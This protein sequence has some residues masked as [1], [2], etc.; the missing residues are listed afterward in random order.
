MPNDIASFSTAPEP[1]AQNEPTSMTIIADHHPSNAPEST[2]TFSTARG[3]AEQNDTP[4]DI[5][6]FSTAPE[7]AAQNEPTSMT[8]TADHHTNPSYSAGTFSS[9]RGPVGQNDTPN[10]IASFSTAPEPAEQNEPAS[11]TFTAHHNPANVPDFS[12]TFSTAP[13]PAA[14]SEPAS[15]TLASAATRTFDAARE[16]GGKNESPNA[17]GSFSTSPEP[18]RQNE[19]TN[20]TYPK[21]DHTTYTLYT[22]EALDTAPKPAAQEEPT[23][24][25][26]A[27][28]D[29][30]PLSQTICAA[31]VKRSH[32]QILFR[33]ALIFDHDPRSSVQPERALSTSASQPDFTSN[34]V[35]QKSSSP[36]DNIIEASRNPALKT[37]C[38]AA[39]TIV[40]MVSLEKPLDRSSSSEELKVNVTVHTYTPAKAPDFGTLWKAA[41]KTAHRSHHYNAE[42]TSKHDTKCH[43]Q[44]KHILAKP[45]ACDVC[46]VRFWRKLQLK[47]YKIRHTGQ[48]PHR[49]EHYRQGFVNL[50]V[51]RNHQC[52]HN[53]RKCS[54]CPK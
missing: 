46:N 12:G 2:G 53:A 49:C 45:Y 30:T 54:G 10:A 25:T 6:S 27:T 29:H 43:Y 22:I 47:L 14:Q 5:A 9:A 34:R 51:L 39:S 33:T 28:G 40:C 7:L 3:P 26:H 31:C 36:I 41:V 16:P 1:A 37:D 38:T 20:T 11:T 21:H 44:K 8:L 17:L 24:T 32:T 18:A 48:Y 52:Q 15:T 50:T 42:R 23:N 19:P 35:A 13:K 4:N